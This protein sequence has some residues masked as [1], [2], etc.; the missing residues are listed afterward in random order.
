MTGLNREGNHPQGS[1][2]LRYRP[3]V[4]LLQIFLLALIGTLAGATRLC[5][6]GEGYTLKQILI[7]GNKK[8]KSRIIY[9]EI[10]LEAGKFYSP[11]SLELE[12]EESRVRVYNL[13]LFT[14][15]TASITPGED[16]LAD[17]SFTVRERWYVF[18]NVYLDLGDR[19]F[20]DWLVNQGG[21]ADRIVVGAGLDWYNF[22]GNKDFLRGVGIGGFERRIILVYRNPH[23]GRSVNH[24]VSFS[25]DYLESKNVAIRTERH[26]RQFFSSEQVVR[27]RF[28]GRAGYQR[29]FG[30]YHSHQLEVG[31]DY[32]YVSSAARE[33]NKNYF[34]SDTSDQTALSLHYIYTYRRLNNN[35][36]P[37]SGVL[38]G[39]HF[40]KMGLGVFGDVDNTVVVGNLGKFTELDSR[41]FISSILTGIASLPSRPAYANYTV[42]DDYVAS[43]RGFEVYTI[44]GTRFLGGR[45]SLHFLALA[46]KYDLSRLVKMEQFNSLNLRV[47]LT[48]FTDIGYVGAYRDQKGISDEL[49]GTTLASIGSGVHLLWI[50][51]SLVRIEG[52][53]NTLGKF[54]FGLSSEVLFGR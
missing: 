42:H 39:F 33:S 22:T 10:S 52:S 43:L 47:F 34:R 26:V 5:G 17:V 2:V 53:Y 12:T 20:S 7:L 18:P 44:E 46:K 25:L 50:F 3:P 1:C 35:V 36:Y 19:N 9:Q 14:E 4:L 48:M 30:Y 41:W 23:L 31:V 6:Q 37:T 11:E 38:A 49:T 32:E 16:M 28:L 40:I 54:R 21:K 45:Q 51:D 24:G 13:D 15:V 27:T 29:R 8:T